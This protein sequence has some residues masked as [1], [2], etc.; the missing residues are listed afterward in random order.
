MK[1]VYPGLAFLFL[2]HVLY[3]EP[4]MIRLEKQAERKR[5]TLEHVPQFT[6]SSMNKQAPLRSLSSGELAALAG[7]SRDTLRYYERHGLLPVAQRTAKGYRRYP[8]EA[9]ARVRL[10]RGALAIGY[11]LKSRS[12]ARDR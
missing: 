5:L 8:P 6:M 9:W 7:I 1:C 11:L 10:I 12:V 3:R 2:R 4:A